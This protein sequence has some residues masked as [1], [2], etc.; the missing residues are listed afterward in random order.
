MGICPFCIELVILLVGFLLGVFLVV[1]FRVLL[2]SLLALG[3]YHG[4]DLLLL[5]GCLAWLVVL[6][7]FVA[8]GFLGG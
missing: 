2:L 7:Y 4:V 6:G 8:R 3:R 5:H 1:M